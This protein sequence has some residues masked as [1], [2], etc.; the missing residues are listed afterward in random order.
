MK[1]STLSVTQE[2]F[3]WLWNQGSLLVRLE[4]LCGVGIEPRLTMS[5]TVAF[6]PVQSLQNLNQALLQI[7]R[8]VEI[9]PKFHNEYKKAIIYEKRPCEK[10]V[11]LKKRE[12]SQLSHMSVHYH[13]IQKSNEGIAKSTFPRIWINQSHQ[14]PRFIFWTVLVLVHILWQVGTTLYLHH[15]TIKFIMNIIWHY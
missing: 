14:I 1:E 8:W 9:C 10:L 12:H 15:G 11:S 3:S 2:A 4:D 5:K 7:I 13:T 6:H